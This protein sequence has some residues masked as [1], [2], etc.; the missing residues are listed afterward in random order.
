MNL[1]WC[2][3]GGRL[4]TTANTMGAPT[5]CSNAI[6]NSWTSEHLLLNVFAGMLHVCSALVL[7]LSLALYTSSVYN[8]RSN[9]FEKMLGVTGPTHTHSQHRHACTPVCTP[10][11]RRDGRC[12]Q[13][14]WRGFAMRAGTHGVRSN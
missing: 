6:T 12:Q 9:V 5:P 14:V 10:C 13:L 2:T 7:V 1:Y 3:P 8:P 4:Q 11:G